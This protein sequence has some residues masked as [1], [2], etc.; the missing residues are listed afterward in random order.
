MKTAAIVPFFRYEPVFENNYNLLFEYFKLHSDRWLKYVDKLYVID[1]GCSL[2]HVSTD[3]VE[4]IER[5]PLSHWQN[6][7]E[8]IR[9]VKEDVVLLLDSDMIIYDPEF[10]GESITHFE[11]ANLDGYGIFD[12]SG[13]KSLDEFPIMRENENRAERK[14]FA[15]YLFFL[16][17]SALRP[18]FDFTPT[19]GK[20]WTDSMGQITY[21]LLADGK[22][23]GELPDDRSNIILNDDGTISSTQ[24][25]DG[26]NKKW[27][28]VENP[29]YGYYHVRNWGGSLNVINNYYLDKDK[30]WRTVDVM[31][32]WE[33]FRL[34]AWFQIM[35]ERTG[36]YSTLISPIIEEFH[37]AP[38]WINYL[39]K[40]KEYHSWVKN[41]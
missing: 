9:A 8:A 25:L 34:M 36:L 10:V 1:S 15:P 23:I 33:M 39:F 14:R 5:P 40:F 37:M 20:D 31:P 35:A 6:M 29:R 11:N 27:S 4:I 32:K 38:T 12:N 3:K 7:N 26:A 16:R 2:G 21:D 18:D 17:K 22:N 28:R 13:S 19:P 30:F 41:I 24:W